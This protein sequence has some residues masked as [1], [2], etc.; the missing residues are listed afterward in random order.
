M[1]PKVC[2]LLKEK[3]V[4]YL[5]VGCFVLIAIAS[6]LDMM[7]GDRML[8]FFQASPATVAHNLRSNAD[9]GYS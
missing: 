4:A 1:L 6:L 2:H 5:I 3:Y 8:G 7:I 9:Y